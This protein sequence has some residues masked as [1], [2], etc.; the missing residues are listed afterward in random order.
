L[1]YD[2][3]MNDQWV[4]RTFTHDLLGGTR[5]TSEWAPVGST[6]VPVTRE[7]RFGLYKNSEADSG[8][9]AVDPFFRVR[10]VVRPDGTSSESGVT[11]LVTT[12]TT[13]G[14]QGGTIGGVTSFDQV[15]V[16]T[17]DIFGRTRVIT[18]SIG[19]VTKN[20]YDELDRQTDSGLAESAEASPVQVRTRAY[21]PLGRVTLMNEPERGKI[22]FGSHAGDVVSADGYDALGNVLR[23]QDAAG[24]AET[25]PYHYKQAYDAI[26]R[27]L[28]IDNETDAGTPPLTHIAAY[29]YDVASNGNG[30]NSHLA[31]PARM[32]S[33]DQLG[34]QVSQS[35]YLYQD[36]FGR[37]NKVTTAFSLWSPPQT[38]YYGYNSMGQVSTVDYPTSATPGG[39]T[40]PT[41]T[42]SRIHGYLNTID[43]SRSAQLV[44]HV[45]YNDASGLKKWTAASGV[46]TI[47]T[48]DSAMH[49]R[50]SEYQVTTA[51]GASIWDSGV[52]TFDGAGNIKTVGTDVF[53]Y[54]PVGRLKAAF[55]SGTSAATTY[56]QTYTYDAFGNVSA[57]SLL[58]DSPSSHTSDDTVFNIES[59]TN[60]V[61]GMGTSSTWTYRGD[62]A[63]TH[64]DSFNYGYDKA[65]RLSE[66]QQASS[67]IGKY[68]YDA[69]GKRVY[70]REEHAKEIFYFRDPT[71]KVLSLFSRPAGGTATPQWD[72][73][74]VYLGDTAVAMMEN[75]I[76]SGPA[77]KVTSSTATTVTLNW[78]APSDWDVYGYLVYRKGPGD[79]DFSPL[80]ANGLAVTTTGLT[81]T[82]TGRASGSSYWY[83][84]VAVDTAGNQGTPS[85]DRIITC[86]DS[87]APPTP[88]GLQATPGNTLVSLLWTAVG[89]PPQ[90]FAGYNIYRR[91][92]GQSY[93]SVPI[94]SYPLLGTAYED[95]GLQ[96]GTTYYYVLKSVD[97][98]GVLSAASNEVSAKPKAFGQT[99][100]SPDLGPPATRVNGDPPSYAQVELDELSPYRTIGQGIPVK[101]FYLHTD[102]LGSLRVVTDALG[103]KVSDHKYLPYGEDIQVMATRSPFRYA[104]Y[105]FDSESRMNYVGARYHSPA[106]SRWL[107]PDP[108]GDGYAYAANSPISYRDPTGL[109][110]ECITRITIICTPGPLGTIQCVPT[111]HFDCETHVDEGPDENPSTWFAMAGQYWNGFRSSLPR[112]RSLPRITPP[113]Q[114]NPVQEP[115]T[116]TTEDLLE[117]HS[118]EHKLWEL[119]GNLGELVLDLENIEVGIAFTVNPCFANISTC[120]GVLGAP[121][122]GV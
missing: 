73:D 4:A 113:R 1:K 16:E 75:P 96:N 91:T 114:F 104:G 24:A 69:V 32:T 76:P 38:T 8:V 94:N 95:L 56:T 89:S 46:K 50:V 48:P 55:L 92:T 36:T 99:F 2:D 7:E 17:S 90:D 19:M 12:Q 115:L 23:Y 102:H 25:I 72:R 28:T 14:V 11:G 21:D 79:P 70:R 60:R 43:S 10:R 30:V 49:G 106:S 13:H 105:E 93:G 119:A 6:G 31:R 67:V 118:V 97:T 54:D 66:V 65:G 87:T 58:V 112:P 88:S 81:W 18:P 40:A 121:P 120:P 22:W 51:S 86:G 61:L 47:L 78:F 33:Y 103:A 108:L 110:A 80:F 39:G 62:G 101:I 85:A 26:G 52:Y 68:A 74:F 41:V 15:T 111:S 3:A 71:G 83:R 107:T 59:T 20:T 45:L 116:T 42:L 82:D 117:Q 35:D 57:K 27:L 63:L 100:L 37:L 77:W 109:S 98:A 44:N 34:S 122:G 29:T 5:T 53:T 64:D 84:V 9:L